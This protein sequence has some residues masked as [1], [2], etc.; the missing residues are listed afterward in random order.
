M[1][2]K[3][4][5][6]TPTQVQE[7]YSAISKPTIKEKETTTLQ[8]GRLWD[9]GTHELLIDRGRLLIEPKTTSSFKTKIF[10]E[11]GTYV[12]EKR[13]Q[14]VL[15]MT[16]ASDTM[17][18]AS[19]TILWVV[20]ERIDGRFSLSANTTDVLEIVLLAEDQQ[21]YQCQ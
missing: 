19:D 13:R 2:L 11:E 7:I 15:T 10:P 20:N 8:S 3:D 14:L 17:T 5:G 18:S 16:S 1:T 4:N 9:S 21:A 12:I 6:F